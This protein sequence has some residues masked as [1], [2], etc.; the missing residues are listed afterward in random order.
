[1]TFGIVP[2]APLGPL[3]SLRG[4]HSQRTLWVAPGGDLARGNLKHSCL[5]VKDGTPEFNKV[6][7][8]H[9]CLNVGSG[10]LGLNF[11][12]IDGHQLR[13][14]DEI[15]DTAELMTSSCG[16]LF[17]P[18]VDTCQDITLADSFSCFDLALTRTNLSSSA[19]VSPSC[20]S[21]DSINSDHECVHVHTHVQT[22]LSLDDT[23]RAT[24]CLVFADC[25][26]DYFSVPDFRSVSAFLDF[27]YAYM[28]ACTPARTH[29]CTHTHIQV[30]AHA[31]AYAHSPVPSP[32]LSPSCLL[33]ACVGCFQCGFSGSLPCWLRCSLRCSPPWPCWPPLRSVCLSV[34]LSLPLPVPLSVPVSVPLSCLVRLSLPA[35]VCPCCCPCFCPCWCP[36][37]CPCCRLCFCPCLACP[38]PCPSVCLSS[39]PSPCPYVCLSGCPSPCPFLCLPVSLSCLPSLKSC[40]SCLSIS[41]PSVLAQA[42]VQAVLERRRGCN[43][44][45]YICYKYSATVLGG[46]YNHPP[47]V[48]RHWAGTWRERLAQG[49][50]CNSEAEGRTR[51]DAVWATSGFDPLTQSP[52]T[53]GPTV[54]KLQWMNCRPSLAQA[55]P[56][57]YRWGNLRSKGSVQSG[58]KIHIK[59]RWPMRKGLDAFAA[60]THRRFKFCPETSQQKKAIRASLQPPA[61]IPVG[62]GRGELAPQPGASECE[63]QVTVA[64]PRCN[65]WR[66]ISIKRWMFKDDCDGCFDDSEIL[67]FKNLGSVLPSSCFRGPALTASPGEWPRQSSPIKLNLNTGAGGIR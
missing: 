18:K 25:W 61:T 37:F 67:K 55:A 38:S 12:D 20:G 22:Y 62:T 16:E 34:P 15:L 30:H 43:P 45:L 33:V 3:G 1:M 31:H 50:E 64:G 8:R 36:C 60:P 11:D 56:D 13:T 63:H 65:R 23:R 54:S 52:Q 14:E 29:A 21:T 35:S 44:S 47:S 46:K 49:R 5:N 9:S 58:L 42:L 28:H 27:C 24:A 6:S 51:P 10:I 66:G 59:I 57:A 26:V 7:L 48:V 39:C 17:Q 41:L 19:A 53:N 40:Q 2:R 4:F 32:P